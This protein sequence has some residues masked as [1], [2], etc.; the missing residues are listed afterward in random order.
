MP[1]QEY[2]LKHFDYDKTTGHFTKKGKVYKQGS[3]RYKRVR[4]GKKVYALHRLIWIYMTGDDI[5]GKEI[6]HI[7]RDTH[8]NRWSNLRLTDRSLNQ[9][10]TGQSCIRY[11]DKPKPYQARIT[12]L[13][14]T[15]C[16]SFTTY[17]EAEH[18]VKT[19]KEELLK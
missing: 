13:G 6:D 11:R 12:R 5:E 9:L 3:A 14:K 15:V 7:N 16:K 1:T 8:D 10:N 2:L 4:I 19:T 18:Y 17:Q